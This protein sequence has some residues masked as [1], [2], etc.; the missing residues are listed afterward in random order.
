MRGLLV[1]AGLVAAGLAASPAEAQLEGFVNGAGGIAVGINDDLAHGSGASWAVQGQA[2]LNLSRFVVG[3]E[4]AQFQP[5][6]DRKVKVFGAFFRIAAFADRPVRPYLVTGLGAYRYSAAGDSRT[7]IGGSVGP[8]A[9][10]QLRG[11]PLSF[12]LEARFHTTFDRQPGL[13]TQQFLAILAGAELH[14]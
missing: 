9:L 13:N 6:T 7:S 14:F 8:G 10:F 11:S 4:L 5:T 1:L 3:G 12:L 2:G